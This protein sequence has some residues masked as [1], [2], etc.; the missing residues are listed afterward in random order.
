MK[1]IFAAHSCFLAHDNFLHYAK[2]MY[3]NALQY[4]S[5]LNLNWN[6]SY[7]IFVTEMYMTGF[8]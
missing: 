8:I 3:F 1:T 7:F 4:F 5:L 2:F 6:T